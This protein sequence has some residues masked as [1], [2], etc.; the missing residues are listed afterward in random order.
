MIIEYK[1]IRSFSYR[2]RLTVVFGNT[3]N[4]TYVL[5]ST[6]WNNSYIETTVFMWPPKPF[7]N[8]VHGTWA[9]RMAGFP[10]SRKIYIYIL[11]STF[12]NFEKR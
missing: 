3:I 2:A 8:C 1:N 6:L 11:T 9:H 5:R 12:T 7:V 10:T 4:R